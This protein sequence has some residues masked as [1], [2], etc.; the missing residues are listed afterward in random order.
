MSRRSSDPRSELRKAQ[1]KIRKLEGLVDD[2]LD[3]LEDAQKFI[4]LSLAT[5]MEESVKHRSILDKMSALAAK[6]EKELDKS[7]EDGKKV[8]ETKSKKYCGKLKSEEEK[9]GGGSS[10][11]KK[12][13]GEENVVKKKVGGKSNDSGEF[14]GDA[15][16]VSSTATALYEVVDLDVNVSTDRD[17]ASDAADDDDNKE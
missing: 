2:L 8:D 9:G 4:G 1:R 5:K 14:K 16:K 7:E 10:N 3:G 11:R 12:V 6:C 13:S 15:K 17:G